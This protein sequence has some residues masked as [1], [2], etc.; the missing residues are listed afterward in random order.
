V[1]PPSSIHSTSTVPVPISRLVMMCLCASI[2]CSAEFRSIRWKPMKREAVSAPSRIWMSKPVG[3]HEQQV[4]GDQHRPA[5]VAPL[6]RCSSCAHRRARW[7]PAASPCCWCACP[8]GSAA[9]LADRGRLLGLAAEHHLAICSRNAALSQRSVHV[10]TPPAARFRCSPARPGRSSRRRRSRRRAHAPP[11]A[12]A[13]C[14]RARD[15]L[16]RDRALDRA[17]AH[18]QVALGRS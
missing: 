15:G 7:R 16:D 18:A 3:E 5:P 13:C 1:R 14:R 12:C 17:L 11:A 2:T 8:R 10:S 4:G 9:P 6:V